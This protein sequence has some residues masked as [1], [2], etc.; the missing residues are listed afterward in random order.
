VASLTLPPWP[1]G[2]AYV[3]A[4]SLFSPAFTQSVRAVLSR[5]GRMHIPGILRPDAAQ[6]IFEEMTALDW[7]VVLNGAENIYDLAQSDVAALSVERQGDLL[8]AVHAQASANFQF[9]YDSFRVSDLCEGG[10]LTSGPLAELFAA[11]NS[12]PALAAFRALTGDDRIVYLDAQATRYRPGHFLTCHDDDV[13]GKDRLY[14]YVLNLTPNWRAD[15]GGLLTFLDADGHVAEAYTPRWN[16][17]NILKVPQ[18]HA[19]SYVAPIAQG[20]RYSVTGWMRS[21]RP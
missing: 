12:E 4:A 7:R 2:G 5:S 18:Q 21:R 10:V 15:W 17:L 14:A 9:L 11:L 1:T 6:R 16:A 8:R 19:V 13:A 20:A 3:F